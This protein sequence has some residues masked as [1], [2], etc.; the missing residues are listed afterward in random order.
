MSSNHPDCAGAGRS[1]VY[2]IANTD[3]CRNYNDDKKGSFLKGGIH[4][5]GR[6]LYKSRTNRIL[7]GVCGGIGE[8][9]DIDP[10]LIRLLLVLLC[11]TGSGLLAYIIAAIII[12]EEPI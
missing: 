10:T 9:F 6:K 3:H 2:C 11:C 12:P 1:H 7:C 4:M 5:N 8:F